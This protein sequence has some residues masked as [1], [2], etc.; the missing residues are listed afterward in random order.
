MKRSLRIRVGEPP[1]TASHESCVIGSRSRV[2]GHWH[3]ASGGSSPR[4]ALPSGSTPTWLIFGVA[5]CGCR[6]PLATRRHEALIVPPPV[7][8]I[9]GHGILGL[10]SLRLTEL[11]T[12][13]TTGTRVEVDSVGC[14]GSEPCGFTWCIDVSSPR[15]QRELSFR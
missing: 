4:T 14:G 11:A 13:S 5:F 6:S 3:V 7:A 1:C 2:P 10:T 8:F 12:I 15:T 9:E